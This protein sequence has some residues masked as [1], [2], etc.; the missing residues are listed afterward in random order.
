LIA[1]AAAVVSALGTPAEAATCS[2]RPCI[3]IGAFN[4][5]LLGTGGP[6]DTIAEYQEIGRLVDATMDLDVFVLEEINIASRPW[7][8]LKAELERRGYAIA[9]ESSFGGE[10][11][12]HIVVVYRTDSVERIGPAPR[13]LGF[14][15]TYEEAGT[16]CSYENIRPPVVASFRAGRF[17]FRIMGVHL[18]SMVPVNGIPDCDDRI[19]ADQSRRIVQH[20]AAAQSEEPDFVILGDFNSEFPAPENDPFRMAGF[21]SAMEDRGT[22]S[23]SLSYVGRPQGLIDQIVVRSDDPNYVRRSGLAYKLTRA[24][25]RFYL[26]SVSDHVPIRASFYTDRDDD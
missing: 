7:A 3:N 26:G 8:D 22:T 23:G 2:G 14:P 16:R 5:K 13:D 4:I 15:T 19:R 25:Q 24:D 12:Q 9:F 6:A 21:R 11:Q 18:K 1:G 20:V 17:D 10:R